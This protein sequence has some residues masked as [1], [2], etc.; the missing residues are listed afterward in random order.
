MK[1]NGLV[2]Q[3]KC[4]DWLGDATVPCNVKILG[5]AWTFRVYQQ[6]IIF[7]TSKIVEKICA[8]KMKLI[9]PFNSYNHVQTQS[10]PNFYQIELLNKNQAKT[11][12]NI[13]LVQERFSQKWIISIPSNSAN[14]IHYKSKH[15][16]LWIKLMKENRT[17][18]HVN[19]NFHYSITS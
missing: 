7:I 4:S 10:N 1:R 14:H 11:Y 9:T 13:N 16:F 8:Q 12:F 18:T 19:T 15:H 2:M 5:M 3:I 6:C 17:K